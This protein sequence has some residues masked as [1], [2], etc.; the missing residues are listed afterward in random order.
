MSLQL[1]GLSEFGEFGRGTYGVVYRARQDS[2]RRYVA[3]KVLATKLDEEAARRFAQECSALGRLSGHPHIVAVHEAG[4]TPTGEPYLVMPFC[5]RGSLA[6]R[7]KRG[8]LLS[9]QEALDV[10][11]R[12][13]GALHTAHDAG[14]LHRDLKP[15]NVL[16]DGFGNPQLADF[17]QARHADSELT[18][19]GMVVG[20][21]AYTAP[22]VLRGSAASPVSDVHSLAATL[23]ALLTGR[24]PYSHHPTEN[25]AA[26]MYRVLNEAPVDLRAR[27]VP[28]PVCGVLGWGLHKDPA[29]RAPSAAVFGKAMQGLQ[30]RLDLPVTALTAPG[31]PATP[32]APAMPTGDPTAAVRTGP[33]APPGTAS[34]AGPP[35]PPGTPPHRTPSGVLPVPVAH[36]G[37]PGPGP[38]TPPPTTGPPFSA[39]GP[40]A[41]QWPRRRRGWVPW[42]AA[43]AVLVVAVATTLFL[44]LRGG[45]APTADSGRLLLSASNYGIGGLRTNPDSKSAF[46]LLFGEPGQPRETDLANCLGLPVSAIQDWTASA[47]YTSGTPIGGSRGRPADFSAAQSAGLVMDSDDAARKMTT[48]WTGARFDTCQDSLLA[49][50]I[51]LVSGQESPVIDKIRTADLPASGDV[52][53]SATYAGKRIDVPLRQAS[54]GS[55]DHLFVDLEIVSS[56]RSVVIAV[57][58]HFPSPAPR[59]VQAATTGAMAGKLER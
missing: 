11:V 35:T 48:G 54:T 30:R 57:I 52:P 24:G 38:S 8:D 53:R 26:V 47:V 44:V 1:P 41:G 39:M 58:Q 17:G 33:S 21:P 55:I 28:E 23:I 20:T 10:G 6:D 15:A 50:G 12:L 36:H 5:E 16:V 3:V 14:I 43:G 34:T 13:A 2:L 45:D 25:V 56:G 29:Q 37:P 22:E 27:G 59:A 19:T 51:A 31:E 7:T 42:L 49:A 46:S 32:T 40:A 9:W 18:G 4:T